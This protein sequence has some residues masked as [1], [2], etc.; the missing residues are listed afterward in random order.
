[1]EDFDWKFVLQILSVAFAAGVIYGSLK[2]FRA[3]FDAHRIES[4]TWRAKL[5]RTLFGEDGRNGLVGDNIIHGEH[6]KVCKAH[7]ERMRNHE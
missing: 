1:M 6:I 3:D 2:S 4:L 5:E 7:L